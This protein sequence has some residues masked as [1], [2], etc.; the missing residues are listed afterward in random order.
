MKNNYPIK[1]AVI[2]MYEQTGWA[3]GLNEL[4]RDYNVVA[5]IVSKCYLINEIKEYCS[6]GKINNKYEIVFPFEK[7][8][9]YSEW[10]R[11][12]PN[13]N[14]VKKCTNSIT[15]NDIFENYIDASNLC[16]QKNEQ[17]LIQRLSQIPFDKLEEQIE[18]EKYKQDKLINKYFKLEKEILKFT[19]DL[20][21]KEDLKEQSIIVISPE[22]EKL[23]DIS[24][25]DYINLLETTKKPFLVYNISKTNY[26]QIKKKILV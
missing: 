15:V 6:N 10:I 9:I 13:F 26:E 8:D 11:I 16:Q 18:R 25:Y 4:E 5:Y 3:H 2:P 21:P 19:Q 14:Y 22:K 1:Y 7:T 20:N 17:L 24:L 12:E 23:M